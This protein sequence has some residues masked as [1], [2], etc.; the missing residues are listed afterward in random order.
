MTRPER[1][2]SYAAALEKVLRASG[3]V[4]LDG[5]LMWPDMAIGILRFAWGLTVTDTKAL[6]A[7]RGEVTANEK[8]DDV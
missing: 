4:S 3:A 1:M 7:A 2:T 8:E 6:E 5:Q